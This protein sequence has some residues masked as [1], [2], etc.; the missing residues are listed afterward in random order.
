M[1]GGWTAEGNEASP[2]CSFVC[3]PIYLAQPPQQQQ[4][5]L[6][7]AENARQAKSLSSSARA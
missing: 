2:P 4:I 3:L 6:L 7:K 1:R 5:P